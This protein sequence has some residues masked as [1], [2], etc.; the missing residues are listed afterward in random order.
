MGFEEAD[1]VGDGASAIFPAV[2]GTRQRIVT[3]VFGVGL[4]AGVPLLLSVALTAT[5]GDPSFVILPLPFLGVLWAIQGLAPA[6]FTLEPRGLRLDRR[7]LARR[8]PYSAIH[9]VD[10]TARPIGGFLALGLNG[11]FGAHGLRWNP[12][13]G[14]HYLA[15]TNT[16]DL[17]YVHTTQ[18]LL[19]ISPSRPGEFVAALSTRLA[20]AGRPPA[21]PETRPA[22]R[23]GPATPGEERS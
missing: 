6:G 1:D 23:S 2:L 22:P 8:V 18:G 17:V 19:V 12:R 7:W 16:T 14:W 13:T 15:I 3:G 9:S 21:P 10:R 11:L 4:G 20:A 5:S